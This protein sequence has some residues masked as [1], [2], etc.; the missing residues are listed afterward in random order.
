MGTTSDRLLMHRF[1]SRE[2]CIMYYFRSYN[3]NW[4]GPGQGIVPPPEKI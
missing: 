3:N 2:E 1:M 4:G